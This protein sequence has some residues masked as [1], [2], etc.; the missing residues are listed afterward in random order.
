VPSAPKAGVSPFPSATR[1]TGVGERTTLSTNNGPLALTPTRLTD[2]AKKPSTPSKLGHSTGT[3]FL[4]VS[5]SSVDLVGHE[6]GPAAAKSRTFWCGWTRISPIYSPISIRKSAA[7]FVVALS[8]DHGVVPIPKNMQSTGADAGVLHCRSA[9]AHRKGSRI[10]QLHQA[11]V[12]RIT[13]ATFISPRR[14][15]KAASRFERHERVLEAF[16]PPPA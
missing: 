7:E 16:E 10:V 4:A 12:A 2:L 1:K 9:G 5:Y 8:A 3:D 15:R 11:R 14:L 13:A 6:F